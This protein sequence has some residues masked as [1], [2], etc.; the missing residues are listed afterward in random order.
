MKMARAPVLTRESHSIF[1]GASS[2]SLVITYPLMKRITYWPQAVLGA[3]VLF[4]S[5]SNS[6]SNHNIVPIPI[7]NHP[8]PYL[9][10]PFPPP[11]NLKKLSPFTHPCCASSQKKKK[12][13]RPRVQLGCVPRLVSRVWRS[14]L[15]RRGCVICGWRVLDARI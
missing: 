13:N 15:A 7:P 14:L 4:S 11:T 9:L 10:T 12:L 1:L 5:L 6:T 3:C 8:H 2:L